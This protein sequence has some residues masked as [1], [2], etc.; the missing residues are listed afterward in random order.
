LKCALR[1]RR[2]SVSKEASL[3]AAAL[4]KMV[5]VRRAFLMFTTNCY[6]LQNTFAVLSLTRI[7]GIARA[8]LKKDLCVAMSQTLCVVSQI[9]QILSHH[10]VIGE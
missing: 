5:R 6:H 3:S 7:S 10:V 2:S 9:P 8:R 1:S 4:P